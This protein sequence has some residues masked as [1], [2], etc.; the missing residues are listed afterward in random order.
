MA[1]PSDIRQ[2]R[3]DLA[4]GWAGS[5]GEGAYALEKTVLVH[6]VVDRVH[7]GGVLGASAVGLRLRRC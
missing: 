5:P 4:A 1:V 6:V 2:G 3:I 7:A